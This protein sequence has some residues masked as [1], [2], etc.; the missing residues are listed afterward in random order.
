[1][2]GNEHRIFYARFKRAM[3]HPRMAARLQVI[4]LQIRGLAISLTLGVLKKDT[5]AYG[6]SSPNSDYDARFIYINKP[7]WYLSAGLE[8][9]RDVIEYPII[10]DRDINDWKLRK[11]PLK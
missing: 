9:Q 1:M 6:F 11:A 5:C 10:D 8:E 7:D 4:P 3:P 2:L